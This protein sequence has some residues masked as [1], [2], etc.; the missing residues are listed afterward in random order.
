MAELRKWSTD[1]L[2]GLGGARERFR[3]VAE[4]FEDGEHLMVR[5]IDGQ[6]AF[7]IPAKAVSVGAAP[8]G[9]EDAPEDWRWVDIDPKAPCLRIRSASAGELLA[10]SARDILAVKR[11][12][13]DLKANGEGTLAYAGQSCPC[14]GKP[15]VQYTKDLTV[16]GVE[17][18][19]KF[20]VKY[21]TE[22]DADMPWA[23]LIMGNRGI[24]IHEGW[25]TL[26]QNGGPTKGCIH[27]DPAHAKGFYDWVDGPT[28]VL[29]S[30]P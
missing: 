14:L 11:V 22:W 13:I 18:V 7:R 1:L 23:V 24:Y 21:S 2:L 15:G 8:D 30:Y 10:G 9:L 12:T 26:A 29:I 17:G 4:V 3:T 20:P 5:P 25:A 27:L 19:D 28:R 16:R 6:D